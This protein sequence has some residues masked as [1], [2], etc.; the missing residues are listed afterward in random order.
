MPDSPQ[1]RCGTVRQLQSSFW[2]SPLTIPCCRERQ[3]ESYNQPGA[4]AATKRENGALAA[5]QVGAVAVLQPFLEKFP[6][7]AC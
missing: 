7:C 4:A 6:D 5:W 2:R 3:T 1:Q